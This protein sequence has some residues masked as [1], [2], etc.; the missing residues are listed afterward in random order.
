MNEL[1]SALD[2]KERT[3]LRLLG[4]LFLVA[5]F[6]FIFFSLGQRRSYKLNVERLQ[7][8]D[9]AAAAAEAKRAESAAGWAQWQEAFQDLQ[10][11]K[12]RLGEIV[13]GYSPEKKLV[14][15]KDIGAAG[16]MAA[17]LKDAINPNLAQTLEGTP[18][19]IHGGPFANIAHGTNSVIATRLGLELA[20]YVVTETGFGSDLGA[21]KFFDIVVRTGRVPPPAACVL[22]ATLRA[23]K[24]HG[25]ARL[26]DV[27]K[28]NEQA[29][30]KGFPNLRKHIENMRLFGIPFVVA[31]NVFPSDTDG[32]RRKF[33]DLCR[34]E[35]VRFAESDVFGKGG[36]G[37]VELA[38]EVIDAVE[39][40]RAE[41]RVLYPLDIP[42]A[43]KIEVVAQKI[44][45]AKAVEMEAKTRRKL[46]RFE[47]DGFGG[48][49]VCIAKTQYSL[50][51]D[52]EA[53]GRPEG[54][55]L[56]ITDVTL[57]AGAGFIVVLC[58]DIM[59]MPG[60]PKTPAAERV[61]VTD[62]GEIT[63]LS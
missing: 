17:L 10:D 4:L 47:K 23:L 52:D 34:K 5:L 60:L 38:R 59:T 32:E 21:E 43:Q 16:A 45:G 35:G 36:R 42:L 49:P 8:R 62:E 19:L 61:D 40:D 54:F 63:G 51:D 1:S 6:V 22:I 29:L 30:D 3:R 26:E 11:L 27:G 18:A 9:K 48:L 50:S 15:A 13:V 20:D 58:G 56:I 44:Y 33:A 55:T 2:E 41:F 53:L 14:F 46:D 39:K 37:G 57:S 28:E 31:L 12:K 24:L 25:G 7:G